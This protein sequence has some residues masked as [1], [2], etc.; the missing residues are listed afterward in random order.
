ML[1]NTSGLTPAFPEKPRRTLVHVAEPIQGLA[2]TIVAMHD[3]V[4][5]PDLEETMAGTIGARTTTLN[6]CH[7][8]ML[9]LPSKVAAVIADAAGGQ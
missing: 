4:I 9:D 2:D 7:L 3:R 1:P 5:P 6:T 8:A